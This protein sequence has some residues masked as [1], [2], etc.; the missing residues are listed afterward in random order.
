MFPLIIKATHN[1]AFK[2][3][4]SIVRGI[5][6]VTEGFQTKTYGAQ[7]KTWMEEPVQNVSAPTS[8]SN[9]VSQN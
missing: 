4:V 3:V 9:Q 8:D 1:T 7:R 2:D 5:Y 6:R